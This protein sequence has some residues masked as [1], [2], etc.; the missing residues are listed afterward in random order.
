MASPWDT[1]QLSLDLMNFYL[2]E[3]DA[4]CESIDLQVSQ[5]TFDGSG[6]LNTHNS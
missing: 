2:E 6:R 1:M 3:I 4:H 5:L